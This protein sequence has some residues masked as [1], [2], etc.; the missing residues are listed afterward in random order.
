MKAIVKRSPGPG[1]VEYM[2]VPEP[3]PKAGEVKVAM[4]AAGLCG[5]DI[6]LYDWTYKGKR[7]V[8]TPII[9]GHEGAG[10]IV[11]VGPGVV[12]FKPGDRVAM[13][14]ILGCGRCR[15]CETGQTYLCGNWSHLGMTFDGIF[16]DYAVVPAEA[17]HKL[18]DAVA[19]EEGAFLEFLATLA[20]T[21]EKVP[22]RLGESV[23]IVGPG[24]FGL[25]HLQGAKSAGASLLV[26]TGL[27]RDTE[28][29]ALARAMGA[30]HT[31]NVE[32][33][34]AVQRVM[35]LTD[36]YGA[37]LVI[38]AGGTAESVAQALEMAR[39]DGRLVMLGYA[40]SAEIVPIS[41]V[42]RDLSIVGVVASKSAHYE[43]MLRWMEAG[44]VR[45]APLVT[46]RMKL[47][48]FD[49]AVDRFR[50]RQ[51]VKVLFEM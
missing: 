15:A 11:E 38:E 17:C 1:N 33:E 31:V 20:H 2:E 36:G 22:F 4:R 37:D 13:Q 32:R 12:D 46:H 51:A 3:Q 7:P 27:E 21:N 14:S 34:D 29:L 6:L 23:V 18:P 41:I 35:A 19:Y 25:L 28:R 5:A 45:A 48:D 47:S 8:E 30:T 24:P 39:P 44:L 43:T 16:A 50:N 10:E 49:E 9:L 40:N 42:R 26:V